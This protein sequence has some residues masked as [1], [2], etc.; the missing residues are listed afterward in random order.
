MNDFVREQRE[1]DSLAWHPYVYWRHK[2]YKGRY[3]NVDER[4]IRATWRAP[5]SQ[6]QPTR[7]FLFGG[8]T[9]WGTGARD[10]FTIASQLAKRIHAQK[11]APGVE[12]TNLGEHGY[13]S[14]QELLTLQLELRRGNIPD[15]VIFYDGVNDVA[16][17]Y[18]EGVAGIPQNELNRR[19]DFESP[20]A[21]FA[22]AFVRESALFRPVLWR[23]RD[24]VWRREDAQRSPEARSRLARD[25]VRVYVGNVAIIDGL[26]RDF[27]FR[28]LFFLQPVVFTKRHLSADEQRGA[29]ENGFMREF[30]ERA[31]DLMRKDGG[32]SANPRF[33]DISALFESVE[34]PLYF[35]FVHI[36]ERGNEMVAEAMLPEVDRVLTVEAAHAGAERESK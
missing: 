23:A 2:P 31:Y 25:A 27:G 9:M 10:D 1:S 35:D 17:A 22:Y 15:A 19:I 36:S 34:A 12:I 16:S 21:S 28:A 18:Q 6:Q 8:S 3:I 26:A 20:M 14:T 4:G 7:I 5:Q 11:N 29:N 33:H 30:F 32:L 24:T 13:V